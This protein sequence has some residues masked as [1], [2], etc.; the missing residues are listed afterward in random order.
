MNTLYAAWLDLAPRV[1]PTRHS[2]LFEE[3]QR[4]HQWRRC[5]DS[6]W[7]LYTPESAH[8]IWRRIRG[9]IDDSDYALIA[10]LGK[11]RQGWMRPSDWNWINRHLS[12]CERGTAEY[13]LPL[14]PA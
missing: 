10:E 14:V 1:N 9:L 3:L 8:D 12:P 7:L 6:L 13:E 2:A 5:N 4:T 11:D